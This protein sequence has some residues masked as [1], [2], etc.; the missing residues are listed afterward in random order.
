M[1]TKSNGKHHLSTKIKPLKNS[2]LFT[3]TSPDSIRDI[4]NCKKS[5]KTRFHIEASDQDCEVVRRVC[6][7]VST[8]AAQLAAV[9]I[10]ALAKKINKIDGCTVA[11]DGSL[12]EKRPLF[13]ERYCSCVMLESVMSIDF[14]TPMPENI[15]EETVIRH[16]LSFWRWEKNNDLVFEL[17]Q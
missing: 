1:S 14:G 2:L 3:D 5:L 13:P 4:G 10:I 17:F 15:I 6:E 9:G 7:A 12:Y 16:L 11:V 8:R